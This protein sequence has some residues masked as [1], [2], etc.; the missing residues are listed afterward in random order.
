VPVLKPTVLPVGFR[1]VQL[2]TV[3][4][5]MF[6]VE[7]RGPGKLLRVSVGQLNPPPGAGEVSVLVRGQHV[8]LVLHPTDVPEGS[9][10]V[11]WREPGHWQTFGLAS[12]EPFVE[13]FVFAQGL[14]PADVQQVLASLVS[15]ALPKQPES[16]SPA[17]TIARPGLDTSIGGISVGMHGASVLKALGEPQVRTITHGLGTPEWHYANGLMVRV[18]APTSPAHPDTVWEIIVRPPFTGATATGFRLGD[19]EARFRQLY[20]T[21]PM[22]ARQVR[23]LQIVA[24]DGTL[25][26][27]LFDTHGKATSF[28]FANN[29]P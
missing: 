19:S 22:M 10:W 7:Y 9:D 26:G 1:T 14:T 3:Q 27:V 18:T 16:S 20:R 23:Q 28:I 17:S 15:M 13:Y 8:A 4:P 24:P 21:F 25:L 29:R 5:G 2:L 12:P 11:T 6:A